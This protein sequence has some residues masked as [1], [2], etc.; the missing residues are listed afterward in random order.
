MRYEDITQTNPLSLDK[1][2]QQMPAIYVETDWMSET[3]KLR[4]VPSFRVCYIM[5]HI[6]LYI[7]FVY[8]RIGLQS[9]GSWN[10]GVSL[11]LE[12]ERVGLLRRNPIIGPSQQELKYEPEYFRF[13][14]Q[15]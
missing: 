6:T 14:G 9:S 2:F 5:S 7:T 11:L 1:E 8:Y 13:Y 15:V 12:N 3:T 4:A 10:D